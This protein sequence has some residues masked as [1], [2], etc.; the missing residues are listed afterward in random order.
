MKG[1]IDMSYKA[2]AV[3]IK[4]PRPIADIED[5]EELLKI[6]KERNIAFKPSTTIQRMKKRLLEG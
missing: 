3:V 1:E 2:E 5:R 4:A 6:A